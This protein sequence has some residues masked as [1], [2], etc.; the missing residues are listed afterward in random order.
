MG[1]WLLYA[2][3]LQ[4]LEEKLVKFLKFAETKNLKLKKKK[5]V[6]GSELEFGGSILTVEKVKNEELISIAPKSKRIQAFAELRKP[7]SKKDCQIF[8]CSYWISYCPQV[9]LYSDASGLLDLLGET[10][11]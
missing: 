1:D 9:E 7:A 10:T 5:F 3:D 4:E 2:M 11:M 8:S 6:I